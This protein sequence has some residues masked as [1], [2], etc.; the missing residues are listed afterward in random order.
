MKDFDIEKL[1]R[2]NIYKTP[3][4]FFETM[5]ERVL[6]EVFPKKDKQE[7]TFTLNPKWL[8]AIAAS[9]VVL[10]GFTFIF[11]TKKNE[12]TTTTIAK[13]TTEIHKAIAENQPQQEINNYAILTSQVGKPLDKHTEVV[14]TEN[15]NTKE[16]N[17][18]QNIKTS[19]NTN[20]TKATEELLSSLS[21]EEFSELAKNIE[22]DIY[23]DL[24]Y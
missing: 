7:K 9:V 19:T 18:T 10:L 2:K 11:I 13:K 3:E 17:T 4:H 23:L 16:N 5:Q 1:E 21:K 8:Y 20:H 22:N 24:Y 6:N 12:N 15:N 14:N